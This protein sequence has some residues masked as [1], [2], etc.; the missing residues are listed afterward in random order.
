MKLT[1]EQ[2]KQIIK[3]ELQNVLF[4]DIDEEEIKKF[5]IQKIIGLFATKNVE[6]IK[7]AIE[8]AETMGYISGVEYE[9]DDKYRGRSGIK[10]H[11]WGF[12]IVNP[13]F[14]AELG[15]HRTSTRDFT[16]NVYRSGLGQIFLLERT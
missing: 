14:H 11:L 3:E 5:Y 2:L 10:E 15:G 13:D 1:P 7:Q 16:I 9:K 4:E 8:L 12:D 6:N